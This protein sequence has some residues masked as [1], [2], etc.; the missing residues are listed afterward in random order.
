MS[1]DPE[2]IPTTDPRSGFGVRQPQ[3]TPSASA[4]PPVR[5]GSGVRHA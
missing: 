3:P 5:P 4:Q 2:P 1:L